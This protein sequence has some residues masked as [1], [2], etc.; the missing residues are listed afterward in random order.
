MSEPLLEC[1]V[2][3]KEKWHIPTQSKE[4]PSS[5]SDIGKKVAQEYTNRSLYT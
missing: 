3:L 5:A 2:V 4:L 1:S